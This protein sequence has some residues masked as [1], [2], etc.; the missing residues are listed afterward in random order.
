MDEL[1]KQ[2]DDHVRS[3]EHDFAI[4]ERAVFGDKDLNEMGMKEKV[5]EMHRMLVQAK[6]VTGFFTGLRGG[7]M[8]LLAVVAV[9][10][11]IKGWLK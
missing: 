10:G 3:N 4:L 9:I 7:L 1:K 8:L 11:W 5:D 6:G 2:F